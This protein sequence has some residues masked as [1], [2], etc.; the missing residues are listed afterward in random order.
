MYE[1]NGMAVD[2]C[3]NLFV[4]DYGWSRIL[5]FPNA[6]RGTAYPFATL[7]LGQPN[8][9]TAGANYPSL[10]ASSIGQKPGNLF[11]DTTNLVLW[12]AD[13]GNHRIL[14]W[15]C[16]CSFPFAA[17]PYPPLIPSNSDDWP[18]ANS[19][20]TTTTTQTPPSTSSPST[21]ASASTAS[22]WVRLLFSF[23]L[24]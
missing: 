3:F 9:T 13:S 4:G 11:Y 10:S 5:M 18:P 23:L 12:A 16:K 15:A 14:G 19:T 24:L 7:V 2:G 21:T 6:D 8:M 22:N 1:P 17:L 20:T